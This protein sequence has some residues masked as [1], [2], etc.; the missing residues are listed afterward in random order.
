MSAIK[1]KSIFKNALFLLGISGLLFCYFL[2]LLQKVQ[3]TNR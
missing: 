1:S 2:V 3:I